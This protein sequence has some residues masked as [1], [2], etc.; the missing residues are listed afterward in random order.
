MK[1]E[2]LFS[3]FHFSLTHGNL[4]YNSTFHFSINFANEKW[5]M[6]N[7]IIKN[8]RRYFTLPL[9]CCRY[10]IFQRTTFTLGDISKNLSQRDVG[11]NAF[12]Q[13]TSVVTALLA[14][15]WESLFCP[16]VCLSVCPS[17]T[18]IV[19]KLNWWCTQDILIQ[20]ESAITLV[21]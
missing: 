8:W 3:I 4:R 11:G 15:C 16:S 7:E 6:K 21:F 2:Y 1:Y 13:I 20:H 19:T 17:H 5:K 12:E 14:H 18:C 10:S 9:N